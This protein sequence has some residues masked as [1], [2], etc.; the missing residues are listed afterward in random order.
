MS[1]TVYKIGKRGFPTRRTVVPANHSEQT[2]FG[3][4]D[5]LVIGLYVYQVS[6]E[7][8][9]PELTFARW[10]NASPFPSGSGLVL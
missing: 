10:A 1:A 2:H 3:L 9:L 6:Y 8:H 5:G 7:D 4:M